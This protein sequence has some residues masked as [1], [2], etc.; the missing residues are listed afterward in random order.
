[1]NPSQW[2][3]AWER[4]AALP[5]A[6]QPCAL[7]AALL[8]PDEPGPETWPL[9]LRD[10][11]LLDL[12]S[13]LFGPA[14]DAAAQCPACQEPLDLALDTRQLRVGAGAA[15]G[16]GPDDH[17]SSHPAVTTAQEHKQSLPTTGCVSHEGWRVHWRL[18]TSLDL[19]AVAQGAQAAPAGSDSDARSALLRRCISGAECEGQAVDVA[20]LPAPV[21]QALA[22]AMNEADPQ[23]LI[24][25]ALQCPA[26]Q[27]AWTEVFD[28]GAFLVARVGHWA[29]MTLDQVHL[30]ARVYGWTEAETLG[31]SPARRSRYIERVLA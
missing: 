26:C 23:A 9:G 2:L 11:A 25:L 13:A 28:I 6:L 24:E 31:L 17:S 15:A 14:L 19:A 16:S 22:Q 20:A 12:H 8:P 29:A 27:H 10:A 30:L 4:R 18:P 21:V 7:L 1:V 5:A 3:D